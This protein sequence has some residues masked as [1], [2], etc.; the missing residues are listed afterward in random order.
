M[1]DIDEYVRVDCF[2]FVTAAPILFIIFTYI[3]IVLLICWIRYF[4]FGFF[5][6]YEFWFY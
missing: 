6:N 1:S 5:V 4:C 3:A 2:N